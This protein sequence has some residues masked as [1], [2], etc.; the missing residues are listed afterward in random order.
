MGN[1]MKVME[2]H[3][4]IPFI[5]CD[6]ICNILKRLPMKSLIRFQCVCRDWKNLIESSSFNLEHL[7]HTSRPTLL[8]LL[9]CYHRVSLRIVLVDHSTM[10]VLEI[11]KP[12]LIDPSIN[13][14]IVGSSNGLVCVEVGIED[15]CM[16]P[17]PF[18]PKE[19]GTVSPYFL[20]WNPLTRQFREV[21]RTMKGSNGYYDVG[22]VFNPIDDDFKIV[23]TYVTQFRFAVNPVEV[24]SLNSGSWKEV[25]FENFEGTNIRKGEK[26]I[27]NGVMFMFGGKQRPGDHSNTVVSIDLT[28]QVCIS[29]PLPFLKYEYKR[30]NKRLTVYENKLA[31][32][33]VTLSYMIHLWVMEEDPCASGGR[34]IWTKKYTAS[35]LCD[36]LCTLALNPVTIWKNEIVFRPFHLNVDDEEKKRLYLLDLT[37]NEIKRF[38]IKCG[39][40]LVHG[41]FD[42]VESLVSVGNINDREP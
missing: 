27:V 41:N 30:I 1:T 40:G 2:D 39:P 7:L 10:Q 11:Q 16:V 12:P 3:N 28:K 21:P 37:T 42:H 6:V 36:Q 23:T 5:P 18:S 15:R 8:L 25:E 29:T 24:Y 19:N 38:K 17:S 32:V 20:L 4:N 35:T 9:R 22:F 14:R 13:F 34:W 33:V 26:V 31:L